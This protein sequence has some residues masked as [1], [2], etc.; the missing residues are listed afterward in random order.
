MIHRLI[1]AGLPNEA[2]TFEA[3]WPTV[4]D[5]YPEESQARLLFDALTEDGVL[6][7]HETN[8]QFAP[9]FEGW[10]QALSSGEHMLVERMN[11]GG[12]LTRTDLMIVP[13]FLVHL[14]RDFQ[15]F[16]AD[17]DTNDVLLCRPTA[18]D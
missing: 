4:R 3:L 8:Y 18:Q 1:D 14:A 6:V 10:V 13:G 12:K 11:L 9:T 5:V 17:D 2:Q 7:A 15:F 16:Q